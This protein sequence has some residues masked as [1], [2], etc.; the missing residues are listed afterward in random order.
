MTVSPRELLK[1]A[2]QNIVCGLLSRQQD[3]EYLTRAILIAS[4]NAAWSV[5]RGLRRPVMRADFIS[6][7]HQSKGAKKWVKRYDRAR[8]GFAGS[9]QQLQTQVQ[10]LEEQRTRLAEVTKIR[11][12]TYVPT[13]EPAPM[14]ARPGRQRV[15]DLGFVR[16]P[17]AYPVLPPA[18]AA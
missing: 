12:Q 16:E 18:K 3:K 4:V 9:I 15:G 13:K 5:I 7:A 2:D 1:L 17:A 11:K 10:S 14:H 8:S 6:R